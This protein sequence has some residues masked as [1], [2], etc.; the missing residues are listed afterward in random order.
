[1]RLTII[2]CEYA[3]K[4]T[5]AVQLSKWMIE[6]MGIPFV[7]WHNHFVVPRLD[8]H[9]IVRAEGDGHTALP[10]KQEG[11]LNTVAEEEQILT[12]MPSLL[13]QLQR[14]NIWRHL[15]PDMYREDDCLMVNAYYA[16]AVYAPLYYGYGEP[17][18]FSDRRRRA[19]AW[20][21]EVTKLAPDTVLV[22]VKASADVIRRRMEE[23]PR[24][25]S[26]LKE[27]DA[28]LVLRRFQEEYDDSLIG[29]RFTLDTSDASV[30]ETFQ[31]FLTQMRPHLSQVDHLRIVS[32]REA[33]RR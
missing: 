14:H 4:T 5:L 6:A 20:D 11:D 21:A 19:R 30:D 2:G 24:P 16:D 10:G 26:I 15:H 13:E 12:L 32:H 22:L 8:G 27:Q 17:G 3:G 9:L 18:S 28:E 23:S 7:R 31:E 29:R 33:L 1:M 25:R